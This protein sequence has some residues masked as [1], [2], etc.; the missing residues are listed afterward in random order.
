[1]HQYYIEMFILFVCVDALHPSQKHFQ[2][3][4]DNFWFSMV[5]T[6][7]KKRIKYL[8]SNI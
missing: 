7:T 6:S 2:S 3:F 1:M 5:D 8:A 4:S